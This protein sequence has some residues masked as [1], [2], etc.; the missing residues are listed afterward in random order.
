MAAGD[1]TTVPEPVPDL[2]GNGEGR[3]VRYKGE[4][5]R[6]RQQWA[7]RRLWLCS[8]SSDFNI[9]G[10]HLLARRPGVVLLGGNSTGNLQVPELPCISLTDIPLRMAALFVLR[11]ANLPPEFPT[12]KEGIP[13]HPV[14]L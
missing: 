5:N 4:G 9:G 10:G 14:P 6:Y 3:E 11:S 7:G 2:G 12:T 13:F 8:T 1:E